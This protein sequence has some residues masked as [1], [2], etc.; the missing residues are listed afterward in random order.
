MNK[1]LIALVV[2]GVIAPLASADMVELAP[3]LYLLIRDGRAQRASRLTL[4]TIREANEFA[5]S[6]GMVAVPVSGRLIESPG[7][8][9]LGLYEYQFRLMNPAEAQAQSATLAPLADI[10]IATTDVRGAATRATPAAARVDVSVLYDGLNKLSLLR[11][12]GL[13]SDREFETQKQ[14]LFVPVFAIPEAA[15]TAT[16]PPLPPFEPD[17]NLPAAPAPPSSQ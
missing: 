15:A 12:R 1:S 9:E 2:V 3:N 11:E 14:Q 4:D 17:K 7:A 10:V 5:R 16:T 8:F 6:K 13:I